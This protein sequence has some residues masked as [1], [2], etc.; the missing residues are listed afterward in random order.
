M[1]QEL[2]IED[3]TDEQQKCLAEL[4]GIENYIKLVETHGGS[5]IYVYKK[6][7]LIRG[8][9]DKKIREEFRGDYKILAQKYNLTE[10]AIRNI[11]DKRNIVM[12]GQLE[13]EI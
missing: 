3:I 1:L 4:L 12:Q 9:R 13:M 2:T 10:M 11:V 7:S 8:I 5:S 6:D